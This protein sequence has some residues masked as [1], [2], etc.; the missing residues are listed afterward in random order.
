MITW[1]FVAEGLALLSGIAL[2][3]PALRL[4]RKLRKAE[5]QQKRALSGR[6]KWVNEFRRGIV[7]AY[8]DPQWSFFD[9]ALTIA[10]VLLLTLSSAIKLT[11]LWFAHPND[12]RPPPSTVQVPS[13]ERPNR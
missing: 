7:R 4:N 5:A 8:T 9:E 10:G 2:V 11:L 1:E 6:S 3:W 12:F 13:I